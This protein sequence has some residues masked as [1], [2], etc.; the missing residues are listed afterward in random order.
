MFPH[1]H[2]H[3]L[4]RQEPI[5]PA[6]LDHKGWVAAAVAVGIVLGF[7][8]MAATDVEPRAMVEGVRAEVIDAWEIVIRPGS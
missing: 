3:V 7:A 8:V 6:F 1:V 2:P 4:G 5:Q